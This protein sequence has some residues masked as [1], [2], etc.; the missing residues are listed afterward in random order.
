M[1]SHYGLGGN[2]SPYFNKQRQ[3][4]Y[5]ATNDYENIQQEVVMSYLRYSGF[6]WSEKTMYNLSQNVGL[7]SEF[8]TN[9]PFE[10]RTANHLTSTLGPIDSLEFSQLGHETDHLPPL[11]LRSKQFKV[12]LACTLCVFLVKLDTRVTLHDEAE[13][14]FT[15]CSTIGT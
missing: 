9:W 1:N 8:R 13:N 3:W 6:G 12:L 2:E 5:A 10:Y 14:I 7:W 11:L 4:Y 15:W